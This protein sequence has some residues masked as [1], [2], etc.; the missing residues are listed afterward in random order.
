M[1]KIERSTKF[2][3]DVKKAQSQ[4]APKRDL[5]ELK[6]VMNSLAEDKPLSAEKRDHPLVGSFKGFRECHVQPDFL[7]IYKAT[8][9]IQSVLKE[10]V[11]ILN[12][13][14]KCV[15]SAKLDKR[16]GQDYV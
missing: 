10:W 7:L 15:G 4:T 11:L 2:K 14:D 6:E 3:K 12:F 1:R 5:K 8:Q 13:S 9:I 16:R